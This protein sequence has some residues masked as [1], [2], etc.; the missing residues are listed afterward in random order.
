M[1][2]FMSLLYEGWPVGLKEMK[3]EHARQVLQ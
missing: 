2:R 1:G 3:M